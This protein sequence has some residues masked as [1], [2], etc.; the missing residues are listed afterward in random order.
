MT[1]VE[2]QLH[3]ICYSMYIICIIMQDY[4]DWV[5]FGPCQTFTVLNQNA[6]W[7]FM[8]QASIV[9]NKVLAFSVT[10]LYIFFRNKEI[11]GITKCVSFW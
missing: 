6:F 5:R 8:K 9:T 3:G 10:R 4:T 1:A 11:G 7:N 2:F